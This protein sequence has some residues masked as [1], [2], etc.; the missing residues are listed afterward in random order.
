[1]NRILII[2]LDGASPHLV[3]R[4]A[5]DLPHLRQLMQEGA[6]GTLW[7]V[8]PPRSIPAWYC[9]ATGMNPARLGVFGF[10]QRRPGTYDYTFAN[11]TFCQAPAFWEWA[12]RWGRRMA[13]LFVPGTF[14]PRPVNGI[15]V[16]GWPAPLNRGG[17]I[18][19]HPPDLSR[20]IDRVLRKPF[21]F[22]S[23]IPIERDNEA[24]ALPE[25]LRIL[26][27]HGEVA[28]HV[29]RHHEWDAAV[30][31]LTPIDRASHQFWKH[32]DPSHPQHDPVAAQRWGDALKRV[33]QAADEQ[34]GRL[35][36]LVDEGD[37]VFVISD[38]GF[39]PTHRTFYLNE[40][41]HRHGYLTLKDP[42]AVGRVDRW[43]RWL[44][45]LSA[46]LF[47]LNQ[48]SPLFRKVAAPFKKRLLSNLL[49]DA[50]VRTRT[51]G[52]VRLNHL[53]VDWSRTLAYCPDESSLYINVRG[54][55]PEGVVPPGEAVRRLLDEIEAG[56]R[57]VRHPDTGT[58]LHVRLLRKE[59]LYSGPFLDEAPEAIVIL[60][61]Y[62]TDVMAEMGAGTPFDLHPV[63]SA[64]HT[65]DGLFIARGP[66]IPAGRAFEAGLM[67]I[68]PTVLHLLG[69]PVPAEADGHVLLSLFEETSPPRIRPV[70]YESLA[71]HTETGTAFTPEEQAQ[72]EQ[73]LRDLGYLG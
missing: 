9:F 23:P 13:V 17:L 16:S 45:R 58:P 66:S 44:G 10:S 72:I 62:R 1:M 4:W 54:R 48:A 42:R 46:P 64:N 20:A 27:E 26:R 50:Y 11:F 31:V 8:I 60:D 49:R 70:Q 69:L 32:M 5:D 19:T 28:A 57:E 41:L 35:L 38:H 63:R 73:Q 30:V 67:D 24:Q 14:P 47:W 36:D 52:R 2:G 51:G 56:L 37:W 68:A 25:R 55:D 15:F 6:A 43:T 7:S 33:Y 29:L 34:V 40:W 21:E 18:Y 39:G 65:P 12:G 71:P 59:A 53:P 61:E 22:D 3:R